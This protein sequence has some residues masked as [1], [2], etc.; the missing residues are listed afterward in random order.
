[1]KMPL[2][3]LIAVILLLSCVVIQ[4]QEGNRQ[5]DPKALRAFERALEYWYDNDFLKAEKQLYKAISLDT[6]FAEPYILLG[7]IAY[8]TIDF[9]G[10]STFYRKAL[11]IDPTLSDPLYY[12][13][14]KVY[15]DKEDYRLSAIWLEKYMELDGL[16]PGKHEHAAELHRTAVFRYKAFE[17][18]VAF[19]PLN[20][21]P[22]INSENDEFVNSITLDEHQL[23]FTLMQPDTARPDFYREGFMMAV[24][25]D[26]AWVVS[27]RAL[28]DLYSLGN[29]GAMSLS[30]DGRHL[31]F[32]SC[33][34]MGG[35]GSCDLYVCTKTASGWSIPENLGGTVNTET[36]DSQPCFAADG[37][38]LY[39]VSARA[40]GQGGSDI[41]FSTLNDSGEWTRPVNAGPVI[42]TPKEEMAPLIHP[43]G[44]TMYFSSRGHSGMGGF[45]LFITRKDSSGQ[46]GEPIN[47]GWPINTP[48][49]E[50]NIVVATNG[51]A[52]YISSDLEEGYGGYDIYRFELPA[53]LAPG[54][55]GYLEGKVY[56]AETMEPLD[57]DIA[58][59]D[60]E[61]GNTAVRCRSE[62][63]SGH[64]VAA[65][66]GGRNYA[67]NVS[68]PGYVFYSE[69]FN[70]K[71]NDV[72]DEAV[73]MDVPLSR[74][75]TGQTFV[76]NNIFFETDEYSLDELSLVELY[77]LNAF[78][79]QN[80]GIRIMICGHTDDVGTEAYNQELSEKRARA[81]YSFLVEVGISPGRLEYKGFGKSQP[82]SGNETEEGRALN[83]R[84]EVVIL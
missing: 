57:A 68:R 67:L 53:I 36:W 42:N 80:P 23:V 72:P 76:L 65:L 79:V 26:S 33:G 58:L 37:K 3:I 61:S 83:R 34:A 71:L 16:K 41:W 22:H 14:G 28:P 17:D 43:D 46:W 8:Q 47:M 1:M 75:R 44:S 54:R 78:L 52:A 5:T 56:D 7:D 50:I 69:N 81:V 59:I 49:D 84:T 82:V 70:L 12:L 62:A 73:V 40:G 77:K 51:K 64:Y 30:P 29:I 35:Y 2:K 21:G 15:F 19:E 6:A 25:Q 60:L 10:A 20:L 48:S 9:D 74:V 38:T 13:L 63:G 45:D 4:A 11:A 27:G 55:V 24:W 18:P 32:T 39:F 66:P 31:F